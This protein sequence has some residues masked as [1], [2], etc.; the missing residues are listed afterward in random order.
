M[1]HIELQ[2]RIGSDG[3]LTPTVPVGI[4]EAMVIIEPTD[5]RSRDGP[6][7]AW[8]WSARGIPPNPSLL[9]KGRRSLLLD[10]RRLF[11]AGHH[12]HP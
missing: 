3:M 2:A 7:K 4:S 10:V 12:A 11:A 9:H 1:I 8:L 5:A 6:F